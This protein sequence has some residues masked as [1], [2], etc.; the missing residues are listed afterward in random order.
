MKRQFPGLQSESQ[1]GNGLEGL[2]LVQVEHACY[3]GHPQKPFFTLRFKIVEPKEHLGRRISGRLYCHPKALWKLNRFLREFGYDND[4]LARD[5]VDE[6][7]L[8]GLMG[9][10]KTSR[11]VVHGRSFLNLEACAPAAEW[12]ELSSA[13]SP[14]EEPSQRRT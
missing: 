1:N 8:V 6:R 14:R 2:F 5:E 13:N 4:L 3:F 7:S 10:I 12:E 11:M 9:I